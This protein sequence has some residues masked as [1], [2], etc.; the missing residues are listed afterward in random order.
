MTHD[1][2][3]QFLYQT[4]IGIIE[5]DGEGRIGMMNAYATRYLVPVAPRGDVHNLFDALAP[6]LPGVASAV[7]EFEPQA[8]TVVANRRFSVDASDGREQT[9]SLSLERLDREIFMATLRDVTA[10]VEQEKR[11]QSARDDEAM[12]RGRSEIAA[13]VL[14]DIGNAVTGLSTSISRLLSDEGWQEI[15]ELQRLEHLVDAHAAEL[16]EA[17]GGERRRALQTFLKEL[18][19][20]LT[21]RRDDLM[22]MFQ[23]MADT[24]AHVSETL[25]VQRQ[26][27]GEWVSGH[28]PRIDLQRLLADAIALQKAGFEKRRISVSVQDGD[29]PML[30]NGDRTK[31]VRV[32]VNILKNAAEAFDYRGRPVPDAERHVSVSVSPLDDQWA[33]VTVCDNGAGFDEDRETVAAEGHTSKPGSHGIG[34]FAAGRIVEGHGGRISVESAGRGHGATATVDLPR[35]DTEEARTPEQEERR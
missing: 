20:K 25:T 34:L 28:R 3:L 11:L 19:T 1:R 22:N 7:A 8:G 21:E 4:P 17:L 33:R 23:S 16:G 10:E 31:L 14:H 35:A 6:Y 26:Y 5:L 15:A 9:L 2:L 18:E 24:V 27:A 32:F 29:D 12:Q 30:I 13:S